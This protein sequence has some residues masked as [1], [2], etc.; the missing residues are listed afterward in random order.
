MKT[1][2]LRK[3]ASKGIEDMTISIYNQAVDDIATA[4]LKMPGNDNDVK[5]V[6]LKHAI[7]EYI[8]KKKL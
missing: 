6:G 4:V 3:I 2:E 8:K 7:S 1:E 5:F